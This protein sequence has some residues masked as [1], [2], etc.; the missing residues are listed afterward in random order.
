MSDNI[1]RDELKYWVDIDDWSYRL[2]CRTDFDFSII[3]RGLS[4]VVGGVTGW[5][6]P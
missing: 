6:G 1:G 2:K 3:E 4:H 5:L